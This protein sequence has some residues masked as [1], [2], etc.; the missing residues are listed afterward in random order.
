[1]S[2]TSQR[3]RA[4]LPDQQEREREGEEKGRKSNSGH[5]SKWEGSHPCNHS[6]RKARRC[7]MPAQSLE[8]RHAAGWADVQGCECT[9]QGIT[10][11][12][13]LIS[14]G[15][16]CLACLFEANLATLLTG[17]QEHALHLLVLDELAQPLIELVGAQPLVARLRGFR[18]YFGAFPKW[19]RS[20]PPSSW[21]PASIL[22][23]R[24]Q[25]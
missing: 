8:L 22:E 1:M 14:G 4:R 13:N 25:K 15:S 6:P 12:R 11:H 18:F 3:V 2:V 19:K 9:R 10:D 21:S 23:G 16:R 17:E 20:L 5:C 24:F 7:T